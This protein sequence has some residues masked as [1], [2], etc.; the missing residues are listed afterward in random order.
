MTTNSGIAPTP[1]QEQAGGR[2]RGL[3]SRGQ[4]LSPRDIAEVLSVSRSTAWRICRAM[5][6]VRVGQRCIRVARQDVVDALRE[7]RL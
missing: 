2:A 4:W 3:E 5:P 1:V 6:H 7:G